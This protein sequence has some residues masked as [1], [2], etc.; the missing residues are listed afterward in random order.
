LS[1]VQSD[2]GELPYTVPGEK[3][4]AARQ[5]FQCFQYNAFQCI[6]LQ[7]VYSLTNE[8]QTFRLVKKLLDFLRNGLADD[9]HAMYECGSHHRVVTY[10]AAVLGAAF[11]GAGQLGIAGYDELSHRAFRY[12]L[13]LQQADGGFPYSHHDYYVLCDRR[14]YPRYLAMILYH[15]LSSEVVLDSQVN[16]PASIHSPVG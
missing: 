5:H 11:A 7:R 10:H 15:L 12:V 6:D 14:S 3:G 2:N 8:P 13:N 9:G 1:E 16:R 4:K